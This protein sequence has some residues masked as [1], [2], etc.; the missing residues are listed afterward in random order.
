MVL[1]G[2]ACGVLLA[3]LCSNS[4]SSPRPTEKQPIEISEMVSLKEQQNLPNTSHR[5]SNYFQGINKL[6]P[7]RRGGCTI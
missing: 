1:I 5:I 3:T 4:N 6:Q 7:I 2:F